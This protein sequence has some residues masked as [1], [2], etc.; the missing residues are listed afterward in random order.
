VRA[1]CL[2][3]RRRLRRTG[4]GWCAP[5]RRGRRGSPPSWSRP[6]PAHQQASAV[7]EGTVRERRVAQNPKRLHACV[8]VCMRSS[9]APPPSTH[10][11]RLE[12]VHKGGHHHLLCAVRK[13]VGDERR[14]VDGR[15]HLRRP[16][17]RDARR[18]LRARQVALLIR[19]GAAEVC[20]SGRTAARRRVSAG[21]CGSACVSS[22]RSVRVCMSACLPGARLSRVAV[23]RRNL[24]PALATSA[25]RVMGLLSG[26]AAAPSAHAAS[27]PPRSHGARR[28][29]RP[30]AMAPPPRRRAGA[31]HARRQSACTTTGAREAEREGGVLA[32]GHARCAH[33]TTSRRNRFPACQ[34]CCLFAQRV[35]ASSA[36]RSSR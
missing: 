3:F 28:R 15:R 20:G 1:R 9:G 27:S 25:S 10:L 2:V 24:L 22:E 11:Q 13:E 7:R 26:S 34:R 21:V 36:T 12:V 8:C 33:R 31:R 29:P 16:A 18:A 6:R 19:S 32:T 17:Q 5:W 23:R 14:R 35:Y 30:P 4:R